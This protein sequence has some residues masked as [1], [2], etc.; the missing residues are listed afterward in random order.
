MNR[1]TNVLYNVL[2]GFVKYEDPPAITDY[3]NLYSLIQP[4]ILTKKIF[5]EN[6]HIQNKLIEDSLLDET[7]IIL[8]MPPV[9]SMQ[10]K[11]QLP[12]E[13]HS[14]SQSSLPPHPP[15]QLFCN[16]SLLLQKTPPP[17]PPPLQTH[18][19]QEL[20][21]HQPTSQLQTCV[22]QPISSVNFI[23]I[24]NQPDPLFWCIYIF[25]NGIKEYQHLNGQYTNYIIKE[26]QKITN[27]MKLND[28]IV[29]PFLKQN[30][31]TGILMKEMLSGILSNEPIDFKNAILYCLFYKINIT[32]ISHEK[33]L[34]FIIKS[35]DSIDTNNLYIEISLK[36]QI[37]SSPN[38]MKEYKYIILTDEDKI[39]EATSYY[40]I[41][42]ISKPL[43]SSSSYKVDQL[44]EI[45]R[46]LNIDIKEMTKIKKNE[47]YN[48]ID[49]YLKEII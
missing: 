49:E 43:L 1:Q 26:K 47:L 36:T 25:I 8:Q 13:P 44:K 6:S 48:L 5:E 12:H 46:S 2:Y 10:N 28:S 17:L 14:Q 27:Y 29:K 34:S 20:P 30:K 23:P 40:N 11:C 42:N 32:F 16:Q 24:N 22:S 33:R 7:T 3:D 4:F 31:I 39:K 41:E 15:Q 38:K 37:Q 45:A 18:Q 35:S 21:L 9:S 19:Q